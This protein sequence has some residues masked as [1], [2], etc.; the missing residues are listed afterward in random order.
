VLWGVAAATPDWWVTATCLYWAART[1]GPLLE[2]HHLTR[3][4]NGDN[5]TGGHHNSDDR[6]RS[7]LGRSI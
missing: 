7:D 1:A 4:D 2:H 5:P 6:R 3:H